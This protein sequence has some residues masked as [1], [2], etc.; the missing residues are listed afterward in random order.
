MDSRHH[1]ASPLMYKGTDAM[2]LRHQW[3]PRPRHVQA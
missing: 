1:I 3:W 2:W